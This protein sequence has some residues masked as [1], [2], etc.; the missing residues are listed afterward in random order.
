MALYYSIEELIDETNHVRSLLSAALGC[1]QQAKKVYNNQVAIGATFNTMYR[2]ASDTYERMQALLNEASS[3]L[4][5]INYAYQPV[6]TPNAR[7][8]LYSTT[9]FVDI[10]SAVD[11]YYRNS[12]YITTIYTDMGHTPPGVDC[13]YELLI[14]GLPTIGFS[15]DDSSQMGAFL[16]FT[17]FEDADRVEI[18]VNERS[19]AGNDVSGLYQINTITYTSNAGFHCYMLPSGGYASSVFEIHDI[20]DYHIRLIERST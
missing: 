15:S 2:E 7:H 12:L 8:G 18:V 9:S 16:G 11:S 13:I 20:D 14:E 1:A 19:C 3:S 6:A 5:D 17:A 4:S 10:D